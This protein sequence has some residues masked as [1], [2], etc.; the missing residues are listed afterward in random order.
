ML[1]LYEFSKLC[2]NPRFL[3]VLCILLNNKERGPIDPDIFS[4]DIEKDKMCNNSE[5]R[6]GR[7]TGLGLYS[8]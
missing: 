8:L 4:A 5:W 1:V 2:T 3:I 7:S 6:V